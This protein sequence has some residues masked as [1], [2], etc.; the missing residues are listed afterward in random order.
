M[1]PKPSRRLGA[2]GATEVTSS[3]VFAKFQWPSLRKRVLTPPYIPGDDDGGG[4]T[5]SLEQTGEDGGFSILDDPD[6][7]GVTNDYSGWA[8][9]V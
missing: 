2:N 9:D 7:S 4:D 6:F 5:S 8:P 1:R 3:F